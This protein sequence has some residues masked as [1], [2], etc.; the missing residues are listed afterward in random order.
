[1]A[2]SVLSPAT[3][4][5]IIDEADAVLQSAA[6]FFGLFGGTGGSYDK[7]VL[8]DLLE[9]LPV[10]TVWIIAAEMDAERLPPPTSAPASPPTSTRSPP[11][12]SP[13]TSGASRRY[14]PP[15]TRA[16]VVPR[17]P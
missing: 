13:T 16:S 5:L 17:N 2:V 10:P 14:P 11:G 6:G 4:V 9:H 8:N 15:S 1:M 3:D 12:P 7:A